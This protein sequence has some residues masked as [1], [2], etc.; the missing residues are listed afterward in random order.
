MPLPYPTMSLS[1]LSPETGQVGSRSGLMAATA[2]VSPARLAGVK[3]TSV[4][5]KIIPAIS[6]EFFIRRII[7]H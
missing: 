4:A 7:N 5:A 1:S 3:A 2:F 6:F